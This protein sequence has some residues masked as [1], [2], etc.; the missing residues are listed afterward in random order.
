LGYKPLDTFLGGAMSNYVRSVAE[1]WTWFTD[2]V[3]LRADWT[4]N[5]PPGRQCQVGTGIFVAGE[6]RGENFGFGPQKQFRTI[7]VGSIH[8]RVV[9]GKGPCT[10]R[11]EQGKVKPIPSGNTPFESKV[12]LGLQSELTDPE[13]IGKI[14]RFNAACQELQEDMPTIFPAQHKPRVDF[15]RPAPPGGDP[16][17]GGGVLARPFF[18][19]SDVRAAPRPQRPSL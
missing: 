12:D 5:C 3:Y 9:D 13:L 18:S 19:L 16:L 15:P 6:P 17:C 8:V 7:G 4:V 1:G 2:Y 10:V 14:E 11:L